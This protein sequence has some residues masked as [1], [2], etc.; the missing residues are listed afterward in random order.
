LTDVDSQPPKFYLNPAQALGI[1]VYKNPGL[2]ALLLGSGVSV[3][4]GVPSGWDVL[5]DLIRQFQPARNESVE[6]DPAEWFR[7]TFRE[8]PNYSRILEELARSPAERQGLLRGYFE[9][10]EDELQAGLKQPTAAH[11]AIAQLVSRGYI[12]VILTTNFDRLLEQ[13]LSVAGLE[14]VIL[15]T[16]EDV[17]QAMPLVHNRVTLLKVNG[18]YLNLR[19]RNTEEELAAY[20]PA[21]DNLVRQV[22]TEYGLI[23]CGWSGKWDKGLRKL[24]LDTPNPSFASSYWC[25]RTRSLNEEHAQELMRHRNATPVPIT[26]S[27]AFF[28]DLAVQVEAHS[29]M[30]SPELLSIVVVREQIKLFLP[31]P[32]YRIRL[33]DMVL[34]EVDRVRSIIHLSHQIPVNTPHEIVGRLSHYEQETLRLRIML[35]IGCF[36]GE[37][38]HDDLWRSVIE[39]L[40]VFD[41]PAGWEDGR[42]LRRYPALL[43]YYTAGIAAAGARNY[44]TLATLTVNAMVPNEPNNG[45]GR[46]LAIYH[47]EPNKILNNVLVR[48]ETF[49]SRSSASLLY[50][51]GSPSDIEPPIPDLWAPLQDLFINDQECH[52]AIDRFEYVRGVQHLLVLPDVSPP[53]PLAVYRYRLQRLPNMAAELQAEAKAL[54]EDWQPLRAGL[55][56]RDLNYFWTNAEEYD[57]KVAEFATSKQPFLH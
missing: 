52:Q 37:A 57:R 16:E 54:R 47:L 36:H 4:A 46:N 18:D 41:A 50:L 30:I 8:E 13:T 38:H 27:D 55:F 29:A 14:P 42:Q 45:D 34:A 12:R 20:G 11:Q 44:S 25:G 32:A 33:R 17:E 40:L 53:V 9:P 48:T 23:I 28:T 49:N 19:F 51:F 2:H 1:T 43:A 3:S 39:R 5:M 15:R 10:T 6:P 21:M 22:L 26:D 35:A 56:L 24:W 7:H 31:N